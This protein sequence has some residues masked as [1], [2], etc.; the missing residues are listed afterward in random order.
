[1]FIL[2]FISLQCTCVYTYFS[3]HCS[4]EATH[5][6]HTGEWARPRSESAGD[7]DDGCGNTTDSGGTYVKRTGVSAYAF[8][9]TYRGVNSIEYR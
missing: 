1:M 6:N 8:I 7:P 4:D 3:F 5:V 2:I 9:N